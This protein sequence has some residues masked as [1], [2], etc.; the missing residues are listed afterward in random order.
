MSP[1]VLAAGHWA[2]GEPASP[3][4]LAALA[5]VGEGFASVRPEWGIDL[6]PFG[7]GP[8]LV[9]ALSSTGEHPYA[10]VVVGIEEASTAAAGAAAREALDAGLVPVVEGG[11]AID[12]DCGFGFL[13]AFTGVDLSAGNLEEALPRAIAVGREI[14]GGR[15]LIAAASTAR[16]L[17][18]LN[19]VLALGVDLEAR[20]TQDR[21]LTALLSR[22]LA[23]PARS[24]LPLA[25]GS[26]AD[27][28]APGRAPGSGAAG[29][30]AAMIAA[31]GGRIVPTGNFL[32]A[33]LDLDARMERADLV[34]VLEPSLHS[35]HLADALLDVVTE[36]AAAFALPVVGL[37]VDS[38]LSGHERA[39]WG[40]HGQFLTEGRIGLAEAGARIARTWTR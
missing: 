9:D 19:S 7:P 5:T 3:S 30:A 29:G 21:A 14:L 25:G 13:S 2:G 1:R 33:A 11:H 26:S 36:T 16:P 23:A 18:G 38:S 12:V 24:P 31:I 10:P 6:V 15:D 4:A 32:R 20:T 17:L 27:A 8:A 35:P 39:E 37:G 22:V 28:G 34:V 40:L